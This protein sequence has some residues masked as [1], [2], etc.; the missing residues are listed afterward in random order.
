MNSERVRSNV[1]NYDQ[2]QSE[3]ETLLQTVQ[4]FYYFY[5]LSPLTSP[6]YFLELFDCLK[7]NKILCTRN[8]FG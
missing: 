7:T 4:A 8:Y 1:K 3:C 2:G 5:P 6:K